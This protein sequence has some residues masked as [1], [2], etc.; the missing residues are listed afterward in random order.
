MSHQQQ[1]L[2]A[3]LRRCESEAIHQIGRIQAHGLLLVLGPDRRILQASENLPTFFAARLETTLGQPLATLVGDEQAQLI[4]QSL[5]EA[6]AES[7]NGPSRPKVIYSFFPDGFIN[8]Q[9]L[10]HHAGP[11]AVLELEVIPDPN[12]YTRVSE[13][14]ACWYRE[15]LWKLAGETDPARYF[16]ATAQLVR[17][18][19]GYDRV[20]VYRFEPNWDGEVIAEARRE[21]LPSYLG[22]RFPAGDI[23]PQA[24]RLYTQNM[25]RMV[26][27]VEA[28]TVALVPSINP[29]TQ[30]PLDMT[31][32]RLRSFSPVHVEYL[33]NMDVRSSLSISLL[34][35]GR[36]WGLVACHDSSAKQVPHNVVEMLEFVSRMITMWLTAVESREKSVL[37]SRLSG[38]LAS[39]LKHLAYEEAQAQSLEFLLDDMLG[40]MGA[41]GTLQICGGNRLS[42]GEVPDD[43]ELDA[44]LAWLA[45]QPAADV[46][47]T[48]A[49]STLFPPAAAYADKAAGLLVTP[50]RNG[51]N[52][53]TLW[54]R[55]EKIRQIR[56]A[57]SPEKTVVKDRDQGLRISPRTSFSTWSEIWRGRSEFWCH[58][59]VELAETLSFAFT[60]GLARRDHVT[61]LPSRAAFNDRVQQAVARASRNEVQVALIFIDLDKF[62]PINDHFGHASG[63][64]V[65]KQVATR[66]K[67]NVRVE[68]TVARWGGDEF[69]ILMED[70]KDIALCLQTIERLRTTVNEP[71]QVGNHQH[72]ISASI[73]LAAFPNHAATAD[74][75][76]AKA[77]AAMYRAKSGGGNCYSLLGEES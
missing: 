29:L 63:D 16:E 55:P 68:D 9:V 14:T 20:M 70:L 19:S 69:V 2:E 26:A 62:K 12:L 57:G 49:L 36:L 64:E 76:I 21:G 1:E 74:E 67:Q 40:L 65:L 56:W 59:E 61:G 34:Q 31:H 35:N 46:F 39:L 50:F 3:A 42:L 22:N 77:D 11:L 4:E 47:Q 37:G 27:D 41:G 60:L 23:P 7:G 10:V 32:S 24:R 15:G 5:A 18:I 58:Q 30:A 6:A 25:L 44:L 45:E 71:M 51:V 8:L 38:I 48:N 17:Q 54:F 72:Q 73:G 66:L 75:L 33:R 53:C 52:N 13:E 28:K 43:A